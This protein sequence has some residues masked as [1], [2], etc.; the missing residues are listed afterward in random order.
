MLPNPIPSV[1]Q[2]FC[3][4]GSGV[5]VHTAPHPLGP[6][7]LVNSTKNPMGDVA[8]VPPP[9]QEPLAAG[10]VDAGGPASISPEPT[11]DEGCLYAN[12]TAPTGD[13][14]V[15]RSQ[16]N[17]LIRISGGRVIWTGNRWG[18]SPDGIKGHEPL[19]WLPLNFLDDN[20]TI[21]EMQW[22]DAFEFTP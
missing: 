18:Q 12:G 3:Y 20:V 6:W 1:A 16:Q 17:Y 4:Q 21:A 22:V 8:C 13:V 10:S 11:P 15:T 14:S 9:Q 7:T 5:K 19:A 2:C